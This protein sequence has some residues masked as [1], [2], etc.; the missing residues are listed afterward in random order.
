[1]NIQA[2]LVVLYGPP[3]SG[4][5]TVAEEL[6]AI[7]QFKLF[8]NHLTVNAVRALFEFGSPEFNRALWRVRLDLISAAAQSGADVI[9]TLNSAHGPNSQFRDRLN[10]LETVIS[11]HGGNV[12]CVH[13]EPRREVLH[14]RLL[15]PNRAS[16]GK[17]MDTD[18]LSQLLEH[19]DSKP[20]D[21]LNLSID[22]SE[23]APEV[24]AR[25]IATHYNLV[26]NP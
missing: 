12:Y 25:A 21:P 8:H 24:V 16:Q 3:G 19:W 26:P 2:R 23:L 4:K 1:M 6:A 18:R 7:T 22:N 13:L 10:D 20:V 11:E 9:L 15:N 17:L 14:K 5:L